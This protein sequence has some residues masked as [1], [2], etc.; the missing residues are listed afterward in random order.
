MTSDWTIVTVTYNSAKDLREFSVDYKPGDPK[1]IVVDNNSKDDTLLVASELGSF[2]N[3]ALEHNV[4]FSKANN[5]GLAQVETTYVAFANPDVTVDKASLQKMDLQLF[6]GLTIAAPQ[7][8]FWNG[9]MQPNG[10]NFPFLFYKISN[11][12]NLLPNLRSQ[13]QIYAGKSEIQKVAWLTGAVVLGKTET[14]RSLGGWPERYFLYYEDT[15]LA[16]SVKKSGGSVFLLGDHNW[17]HG[18]KR[19]TSSLRLRPWLRELAS[20]SKFY[21]NHTVF[22]RFPTKKAIIKAQRVYDC[23]KRYGE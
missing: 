6:E 4:G 17:I 20:M 2:K 16:L 12:I 13:Y 22:L 3:I 23:E 1:W 15:D 18:W 14:F 11:R 8:L 7:L 9:E 21:W 5:I 19:E 10:R